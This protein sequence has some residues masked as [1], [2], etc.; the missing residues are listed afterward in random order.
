[1]L[2]GYDLQMSSLSAYANEKAMKVLPVPA[3]ATT[4]DGFLKPAFSFGDPLHGNEEYGR[5]VVSQ[6]METQK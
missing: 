2:A 1:M 5:L 3:G 4:T 6:I